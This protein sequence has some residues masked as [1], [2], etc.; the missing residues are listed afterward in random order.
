M[1]GVIALCVAFGLLAL[2]LSLS[3]WLAHR[4]WAAAGWAMAPVLL[5]HW[6]S[7]ELVAAV[8]VAIWFERAADF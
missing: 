8:G 5:V 7:W 2:L 6:L 4:P 1:L 3:R